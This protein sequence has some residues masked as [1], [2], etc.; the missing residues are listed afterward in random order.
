MKKNNSKRNSGLIYLGMFFFAILI[1]PLLINSV[2]NQI[3]SNYVLCLTESCMDE[4][5]SSSNNALLFLGG[6]DVVLVVISI[7]GLIQSYRKNRNKA[8]I[9]RHEVSSIAPLNSQAQTSPSV[10]QP[11]SASNLENELQKASALLKSG[12]IDEEEYK[13]LKKKIIDNI[14]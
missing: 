3:S 11:A 13:A 2:L 9:E 14:N 10:P 6:V 8:A 1:F 5:T 12:L 7:A 4:V